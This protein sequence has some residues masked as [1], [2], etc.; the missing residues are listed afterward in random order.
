[1]LCSL[2][3]HNSSGL[4][5]L[6][7]DSKIIVYHLLTYRTLSSSTKKQQFF[8]AFPD[9][10]TLFCSL[11]S[12]SVSKRICKKFGSTELMYTHR[13][14]AYL[15]SC[16]FCRL[17]LRRSLRFCVHT[18]KWLCQNWSDESV[19]QTRFINSTPH[20]HFKSTKYTHQLGDA[21]NIAVLTHVC[22]LFYICFCCGCWFCRSVGW[23]V[24]LVAYARGWYL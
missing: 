15:L 3:F 14:R 22:C 13:E 1:M 21:L 11:R 23:S 16:L 8:F 10:F 5:G 17:S 19:W 18:V 12:R 4:F 20:Q 7:F 2:C 6:H 24:D 9:S